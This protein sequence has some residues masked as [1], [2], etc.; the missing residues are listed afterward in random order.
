MTVEP[1]AP[2]TSTPHPSAR[3]SRVLELRQYTLHPDQREVLIDLFDREFVETQEELGMSIVGQFRDLDDPDRFVW[4]RGFADMRSRLAALSEFYGGPVWAE[5]RALANATMMNSDDVLLLRPIPPDCEFPAVEE[6]RR[7]VGSTKRPR[8]LIV[9]TVLSLAEPVGQALLD[10]FTRRVEPLLTRAGS[11]R[12]LALQTEP[13]RNTYPALP[14][15]EDE[16]FLVQLARY[17][18]V[19]AHT[20]HLQRLSRSPEWEEVQRAL[21][22]HL[23]APS[24]HLRLQPTARSLLQ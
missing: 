4:L 2:I 1:T 15:R 22:S 8:S 23:I 20:A 10:L 21:H 18:D 7:P 13:A 9:A 19:D 3:C 11:P 12:L 14:V 24:R 6:P 16:H 17:D 5:H